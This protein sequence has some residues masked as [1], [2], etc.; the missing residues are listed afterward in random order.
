M[1]NILLQNISDF[2]EN[3]PQPYLVKLYRVMLISSYF[4]LLRVG[5]ITQSDHVI[6]ADDVHIG[7][8][9]DKIMFILHSS[10]THGTD[11]M[12]QIVK[13]IGLEGS[14]P[15]TFCPF[16]C[17]SDYILL[18]KKRA[19]KNKKEPF[20]VFRDRTPVSAYAYRKMLKK[21]LRLSRF[22]QELYNTH[23]TRA[24]RVVDLYNDLH[25]SLETIHKI[26][27]WK[28]TSIYAYLQTTF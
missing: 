23:S 17:V 25:L 18:R 1:L 11:V 4:G 27:R 20:F 15:R 2:F 21:L 14:K 12:L 3:Q 6:K 5:E 26:G 19:N 28:S 22:N 8:N 24:G 10:K 9:K 13:L 16:K 7:E